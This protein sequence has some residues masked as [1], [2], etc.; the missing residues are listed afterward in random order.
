MG[1]H[2]PQGAFDSGWGLG[3]GGGHARPR[4]ERSLTE[5]HDL[6]QLGHVHLYAA[7]VEL[8]QQEDYLLELYYIESGLLKLVRLEPDGRELI[9]GLRLSGCLVGSSAAITRRPSPVSAVTVCPC[10]VRCISAQ[11]L[12]SVLQ[13]D[14]LFAWQL[15]EVHCREILEQMGQLTRLHIP[16]PRV[17]LESLLLDLIR[18]L[19]RAEAASNIRL[20]L[21]LKHWEL[22]RLI[23]ITP[24]HLSRLLGQMEKEGIVGRDKGWLIVRELSA[25]RAL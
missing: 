9:L 17:R 12:R 1:H 7:G 13:G 11:E 5:G 16:S 25:L 21:P 22:A 15:Q 10:R 4:K 23:A 14:P 19:G 2:A 20:Q 24:E 6:S 3:F 8:F 18:A